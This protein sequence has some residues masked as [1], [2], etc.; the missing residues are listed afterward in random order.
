MSKAHN[1]TFLANAE[2]KAGAAARASGLPAL[3]DDSGL[4]VE[5]L[6]GAPG[7]YSARWAGPAKDFA[8][9]MRE[10]ADRL[11]QRGA[12]STKPGPRAKK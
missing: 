8:V 12:W 1:T 7:I 2:L 4:E 5:A 11:T 3:S 10:L 9:A 6:E